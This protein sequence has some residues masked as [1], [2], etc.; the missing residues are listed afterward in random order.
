MEAI[1]EVGDELVGVVLLE[2][3]EHRL[4]LTDGSFKDSGS[5]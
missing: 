4:E 3:N 2:T 5:H 1:Q